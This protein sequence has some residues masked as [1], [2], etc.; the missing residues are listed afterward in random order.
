MKPWIVFIAL[1][2]FAGAVQAQINKCVDAAGKTI[3]SQGPCPK[4]AKASSVAAAPPASAPAAK[5]GDAA[6]STGPKTTAELEQEFRKRQQEQDEAR[7]KEEERLANSKIE[8]E[9]CL[10]ARRQLA[11]FEAGGRQGGVD[12]KGERYFLNEAQIEQEKQRARQAVASSC[13]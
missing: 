6:K 5:A 8:Q 12:E 4:G 7:K 9:N 1:F 2:P 11:S 10:A 13:K 3:Y